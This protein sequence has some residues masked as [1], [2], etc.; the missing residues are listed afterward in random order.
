MG[1]F[2][3]AL[4]MICFGLAWP[5]DIYKTLRVRRVEGKSLGFMAVV[6]AGYVAGLAGKLARAHAAGGRPERVT[7]LYLLNA[8]LVAI[9]IALYLRFRRPSGRLAP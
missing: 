6:L 3:E 2:L 1:Q 8:V 5:T 7:I 4:M 9:D